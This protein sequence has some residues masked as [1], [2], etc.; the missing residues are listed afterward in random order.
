MRT[1]GIVTTPAGHRADVLLH[2]ALGRPLLDYAAAALLASYRLSRVVLCASSTRI[3]DAAEELGFEIFSHDGEAE[4]MALVRAVTRAIESEE[5]R[6]Y[7]AIL[8]LPAIH[9]LRNRDDIDGVI[10]LLERTGADT[11]ATFT[12]RRTGVSRFARIDA[13]G[14]VIDETDAGRAFVRDN[15]I[16]GARRT[17]LD[18]NTLDGPDRRAWL[19][20]PERCCAVED[21]F[22]Y[23]LLEQLLRYPG[24][25]AA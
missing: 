9:P 16:T 1:L 17:L 19:L 20:P 12:R 4:P 13:E 15:S 11:V 14:R 21:E 24:R 7:D 25:P 8:L 5:G 3:A 23:F 2:A 6:P 22:D 18:R 10:G